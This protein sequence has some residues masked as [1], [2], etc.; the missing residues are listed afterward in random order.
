MNYNNCNNFKKKKNK[1][2]LCDSVIYATAAG[3]TTTATANSIACIAA[4]IDNH[5][6]YRG[7]WW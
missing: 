1:L 2:N 4:L 3:A 5:T 6:H 7:F